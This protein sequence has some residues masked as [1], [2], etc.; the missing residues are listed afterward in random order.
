MWKWGLHYHLTGTKE[1]EN[2]SQSASTVE[3]YLLLLSN[4]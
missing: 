2:A 3:P 1:P 4:E